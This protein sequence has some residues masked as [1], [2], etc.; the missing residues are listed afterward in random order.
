MNV[1]FHTKDHIIAS[2]CVLDDRYETMNGE[3]SSYLG[4][5]NSDDHFS[6]EQPTQCDKSAYYDLIRN[7]SLKI[8]IMKM[9]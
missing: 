8:F 1:E 7:Y 5:N 4:N 9:K 3:S 2:I 6:T